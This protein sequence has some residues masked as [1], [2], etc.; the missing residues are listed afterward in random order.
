MGVR[1]K[2]LRPGSGTQR[3]E[4]APQVYTNYGRPASS[5]TTIT[6]QLIKLNLKLRRFVESGKA[7]P[8]DAA[9]AGRVSD[10]LEMIIEGRW[11]SDV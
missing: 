3:W 2:P 6:G 5:R 10:G 9:W 8:E 7:S 1:K 4:G 11:R